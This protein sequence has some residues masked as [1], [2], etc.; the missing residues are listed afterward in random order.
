MKNIRQ[1]PVGA[2]K[3]MMLLSVIW[4]TIMYQGEEYGE[5][6]WEANFSLQLS[7]ML[8]L[9][10]VI[11]SDQST[12]CSSVLMLFLLTMSRVMNPVGS[13]ILIIMVG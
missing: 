13:C 5:G 12:I 2:K 7:V 4:R 1:K 8:S 3:W 11:P 9:W 10:L 6:S